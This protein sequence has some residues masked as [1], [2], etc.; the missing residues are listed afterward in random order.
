MSEKEYLD[1]FPNDLIDK[2]QHSKRIEAY[3]QAIDTR[4]FEIELYWKRATYF[5]AFIAVTFAGYGLA[6][7]PYP[8]PNAQAGFSTDQDRLVFLL[9]CFG[10]VLSFAWFFAN[11]GSKQW[12]E[13]WEHHVDHLEDEITGPLFKITLKRQPPQNCTDWVDFIFTG[14]SGHSVSKINQLVSLYITCIWL[15]L[16]YNSKQDWHVLNWSGVD[17]SF[18]YLTILAAFGIAVLAQTYSG[19]HSH[20]V[21][22]RKSEIVTK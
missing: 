13:N 18:L 10:F 19:K 20:R 17:Q 16:I 14:P 22:L 11:R 2:E 12:Q 8:I 3:K 6:L 21:N 1:S 4:K 7:K 15:I 9:S 5:W